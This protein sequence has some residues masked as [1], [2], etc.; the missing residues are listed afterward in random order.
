MGSNSD[1]MDWTGAEMGWTYPTDDAGAAADS[2]RISQNHFSFAVD[3][4]PEAGTIFGV[5]FDS[6]DAPNMIDIIT[7][8]FP[9]IAWAL[10]AQCT[11][12]PPVDGVM[13]FRVC[14]PAAAGTDLDVALYDVKG[15]AILESVTETF[16]VDGYLEV[17]FSTAVTVGMHYMI[18]VEPDVGIRTFVPTGDVLFLE[19]VSASASGWPF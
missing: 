7:A 16:D 2:P 18:S 15:T 1:F 6:R 9:E 4:G 12:Q 8:P 17:I 19:T 5:P 3:P 14:Q 13:I 10:A 11:I